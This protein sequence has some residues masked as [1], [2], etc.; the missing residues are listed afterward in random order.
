MFCRKSTRPGVALPG[1]GRL[2]QPVAAA[3]TT[4]TDPAGPTKHGNAG[5]AQQTALPMIAS[6]GRLPTAGTRTLSPPR[7]CTSNASV[8][9]E[10]SPQPS[11]CDRVST[12][13]VTL[14][15]LKSQTSFVHSTASSHSRL[16][17]H[18]RFGLSQ[19][20]KIEVPCRQGWACTGAGIANEAAKAAANREHPIPKR[21]RSM[22]TPFECAATHQ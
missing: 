1:N 15:R 14:L 12:Q 17:A 5:P 16:F 8:I 22:E 3:G 13:F 21:F 2:P 19:V 20:L 4:N 18:R 11:A 10:V 9:F 6:I 7:S